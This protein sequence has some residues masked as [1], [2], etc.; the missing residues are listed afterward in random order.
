MA[1]TP[2][3]SRYALSFTSGA[4]LMREA[5][6]AARIYLREHDWAKV[7]QLIEED[8]LLQARTVSTG[9][10]RAREVAQRL[11]V[12]TDTELEMLVDSTTSERGHLLWAAAC[13]RYDLIA[14]FAEEVVRERFQLLTPNLDHDHFDSFI[15]TKALWHEEVAELKDSTLRKL[16][17]NVFRML[18]EAGLLTDDGRILAAVLSNRVAD[19]LAARTPSDIRFFP[20]AGEVP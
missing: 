6:I 20:T 11:A 5:L 14:E 19:A 15:R 18:V 10:R 9:H 8:N 16:R 2:T 17:A 7:R 4:L 12:L 3:A 1:E 13:R